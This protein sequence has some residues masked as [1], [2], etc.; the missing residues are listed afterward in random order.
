MLNFHKVTEYKLSDRWLLTAVCP[1]N[2]GLL[3]TA[4]NPTVQT[5]NDIYVY[6]YYPA[7]L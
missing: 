6:V 7:E 4:S 2:F 3:A 1:F 5:C